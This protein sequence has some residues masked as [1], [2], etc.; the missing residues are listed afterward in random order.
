MRGI[1]SARELLP[2]TGTNIERNFA[3]GHALDAPS[4]AYAL[5]AFFGLPLSLLIAA[6]AM[7][8]SSV[9]MVGHALGVRSV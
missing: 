9:S 8:L 7:S 6:M 2:V 5:C 1:A 3:F 4:A